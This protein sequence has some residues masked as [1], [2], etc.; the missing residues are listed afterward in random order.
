MKDRYTKNT[1][2]DFLHDAAR[3][4]RQREALYHEGRRFTF[5]QLR[6]HVDC[7]AKGLLALGVSQGDKVTLWMPNRPEWIFSSVFAPLISSMS[8]ASPIRAS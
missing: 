6:T 8:C 3:R 7:V 5:E 4:W 2:A 1:F